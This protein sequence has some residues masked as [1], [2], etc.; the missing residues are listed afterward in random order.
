M[1]MTSPVV[2]G[3][4]WD[5]IHKV[6]WRLKL[7]STLEWLVRF[8]MVYSRIEWTGDVT[9]ESLLQA[10]SQ[11]KPDHRPGQGAG[12]KVATPCL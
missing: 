9:E 12:A 8:D 10:L 5:L 6:V 11:Y 3:P 4:K 1:A 2:P 7:P